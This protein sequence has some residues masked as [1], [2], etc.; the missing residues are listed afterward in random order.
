MPATSAVSPI[1]L[2][3]SVDSS[4]RNRSNYARTSSVRRKR[5]QSLYPHPQASRIPPPPPPGPQQ[6][7]AVLSTLF[8]HPRRHPS[9]QARRRNPGTTKF[10][11]SMLRRPIMAARS[12]SLEP[13][14]Q[15][16]GV[17]R[18]QRQAG[19][20][21]RISNARIKGAQSLILILTD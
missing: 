5:S 8:R 19:S 21:T 10:A 1:G 18:C 15:L 16:Q 13:S 17:I 9:N 6:T 12:R 20:A 11:G 3:N 14:Q 7:A 4:R 2:H